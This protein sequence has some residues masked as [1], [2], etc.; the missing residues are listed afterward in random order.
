MYGK[1]TTEY[2]LGNV[3]FDVETVDGGE[4][5]TYYRLILINSYKDGIAIDLDSSNIKNKPVSTFN[6]FDHVN[7]QNLMVK[8][9]RKVQYNHL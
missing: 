5:P 3:Y 1:K 2:D 6:F 4:G 9:T 7:P 8:S